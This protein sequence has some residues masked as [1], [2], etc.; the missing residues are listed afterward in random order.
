MDGFDEPVLRYGSL[1]AAD[2]TPP[3][4]AAAPAAGQAHDPAIL[5][6]LLAPPPPEAQPPRPL[7]P[8]RPSDDE[9]PV[10]GPFEAGADRFRR[11]TLIHRLLQYLPDLP[12]AQRGRAAAQYLA[13]SGHGLTED[14]QRDIADEIRAVLDLPEAGPLFGPGSMAEA[15]VTGAVGGAVISGQIDRLA[16]GA[17]TVSIVDYKTNRP[18]PADAAGT[19][20]VYL[21]QMAAYRALLRGLY[22]AHQID[23][24]LLWTAAPRLMQLGDSLLDPHA[25][26]GG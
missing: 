1:E 11:G 19:P 7:A 14:E 6:A 18:P 24:F 9:P 3:E 25:P 17:Q 2:A 22:P 5:A 26:E 21:R 10:F 13:R 8:S 16:V 12:D 15:P 23:C 4:A 20:P